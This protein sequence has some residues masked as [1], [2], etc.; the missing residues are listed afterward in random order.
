MLPGINELLAFGSAT[1]LGVFALVNHLHART[2]DRTTERVLGHLGSI[3]CAT[4][5]IVVFAQ[6]AIHDPTALALIAACLLSIGALRLLFRVSARPP[7]PDQ[8]A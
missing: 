8:K 7:H 1:F 4:A 6:L 5:I 3:A 2:A